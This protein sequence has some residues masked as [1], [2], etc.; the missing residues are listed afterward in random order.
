MPAGHIPLLLCPRARTCIA[1]FRFRLARFTFAGRVSSGVSA[2]ASAS[3]VC[4][5]GEKRRDRHNES[6]VLP[7]LARIAPF[8]FETSQADSSLERLALAWTPRSYPSWSQQKQKLPTFSALTPPH[9]LLT[10]THFAN[11]YSRSF[12]VTLVS[13]LA[14]QILSS[15]SLKCPL[16]PSS[17]PRS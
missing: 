15:P 12:I 10:Y 2:S 17:H 11:G 7:G 3:S 1:C 8:H 5:D 16:V 14:L 13:S 9:P 6:T 4:L